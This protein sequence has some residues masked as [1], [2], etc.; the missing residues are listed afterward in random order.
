MRAHTVTPVFIFFSQNVPLLFRSLEEKKKNKCAPG[1][2]GERA[3][4]TH[5]GA[6]AV[7][8]V[9]A[10]S[11]AKEGARQ[12]LRAFLSCVSPVRG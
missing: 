4:R 12:I 10:A 8:A 1:A 11:R 9:A 6:A 3:S 2:G 7:T 5:T